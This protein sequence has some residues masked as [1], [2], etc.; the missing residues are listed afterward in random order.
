MNDL[1]R[2]RYG[3]AVCLAWLEYKQDAIELKMKPK[4][5][6]AVFRMTMVDIIILKLKTPDRKRG[7]PFRTSPMMLKP[8]IAI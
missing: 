8:K 6:L 2:R 7:R 4:L 5:D 3:A 1:S